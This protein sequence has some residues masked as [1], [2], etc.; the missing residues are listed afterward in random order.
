[1]ETYNGYGTWTTSGTTS[2][3]WTEPYY[4]TTLGTD[5]DNRKGSVPSKEPKDVIDFE[6]ILGAR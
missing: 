5:S 1:M 6:L 3:D 4:Y 2:V